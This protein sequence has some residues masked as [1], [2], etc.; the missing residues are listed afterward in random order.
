MKTS[1]LR[2]INQINNK[3]HN[4]DFLFNVV[5][6]SA[7]VICFG[8]LALFRI[9][10]EKSQ[11]I[12]AKN[13]GGEVPDVLGVNYKKPI[14]IP[15]KLPNRAE[16]NVDASSAIVMDAETFSI[17]FE[18][19]SSEERPMASTTKM[20]TAIVTLREFNPS[21][22][23]EVTEEDVMVGG[24]SMFLIP[25]EHFYVEDL[26]KGLLIPSGN[27]V[28]LTLENEFRKYGKD[29][30]SEMNK[31][32]E[33]LGLENTNFVNT[34]GLHDNEHYSSAYD[35]AII[36]SYA[37]RNFAIRNAVSTKEDMVYTVDKS[38]GH[39][40]KSTNEL[41]GVVD[42]VDGI[43]TGYTQQAGP[44]LVVSAS[45]E[46]KRIVV[47]VLNSPDRFN[48]VEKLVEWSFD[49]FVWE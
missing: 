38:H 5:K 40:L 41:L 18:K 29:I 49:S 20:M 47:V 11:M 30:V 9:G 14:R 48:E 28:A 25:G 16:P 1:F 8:V 26:I 12:L 31:Y 35:L 42:G 7:L 37:M 36:A 34:S 45:R 44:C 19:N 22:I 2:F 17:L 33:A 15:T 6:F 10:V 24:S 43:K 13:S 46:E 27:D 21:R 32:S 39:Y 4:K 3:F 23:I